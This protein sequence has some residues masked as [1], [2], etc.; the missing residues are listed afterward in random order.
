MGQSRIL[1]IFICSLFVLSG[2]AAL[3]YQV[4]WFKQLS[5][6]I[7]NTTYSQ[8]VVLATYMGG[9]AVGAWFWGKKADTLKNSLFLF[10]ILEI[11]LALYCF[12]YSPIFSFVEE[13][14]SA[15]VISNKWESDGSS[16]LFLK[17]LV[18]G[19]T[20]FFP[21]FLMGGTLPVLVRFLSLKVDQV[22]KN[23]SI[24][25]FI[26]SLGAVIGTLLAGFYLI[27]A[28]GLT[29]TTYFAALVELFVGLASLFLAKYSYGK[30]KAEN[31]ID[32]SKKN[33]KTKIITISKKQFNLIIA[34]AAFSGFSAMIYEVVW[35]RLLI[36]V[37]SS[38]TYSFTI[39]LAAFITG[40]AI[41]SYL[42]FK[43]ND[44]IKSPLLFVGYCQLFIVISIF[45]TLPFYEYL[46]YQIWKTINSTLNE[47]SSYSYYLFVQFIYVFIVLV[48]PTI[49]MGMSLPVLSRFAVS[50]VKKSGKTIGNIFAVNTLGTVLGSLITGLILIPF[51]GI[52][53]TIITAILINLILALSVFKQKDLITRNLKIII[54]S[55]IIMTGFIFFKNVNSQSWAYPIM[56]SQVPRQI[57][58]STPPETYDEFIAGLKKHDQI[59]YYNEGIGG[60]I[61][62]G[63]NKDQIY[64][65]TNGK[66][67]ANSV[68]DLRTQVS[69]GQTPIILHPKA[70]SVFVIGYGAGTTIGNVMTHPNVK[71]AEVAEISGEVIEASSHFNK[72]NEQP[73]KRKNLKVIKDDGVSALRLSTHKYDVIISQPSNPWSA[74]VGNLF[75]KEFFQDC[76]KKLR[77]G[78]YVA[79]WFSFYEM[80]DKSLRLILRTALDQFK[81]VS[82]WH[83]GSSDILLLCSETPFKFDLDQIEKNYNGVKDK[84]KEIN[85][86]TFSTFLSQQIISSTENLKNYVGP[87][88]INTEDHPLLELWAPEAYF[89]N[90][91]PTKFIVLDERKR[92]DQSNN[93]LLKK[94]MKKKGGLTQ[95]EIL[96]TGLFQ[97][98]GG[99]KELAFYMAEL[100]PDI[101]VTWSRKAEMAGDNNKAMEYLEMASKKG[102][103]QLG[104]LH[105][106]KAILHGKNGD[107]A[108]AISEIN[109][110]IKENPA[111]ANSH[112]QK[113][114]FHLSLKEYQKSM[115]ALEQ[116]IKLDPYLIDAYNNLAIIKGQQK[117][118][119]GVVDILDK[120]VVISDENSKVFFNRAYA[121]GFLSD[122]NGAIEDFTMTIKLDPGNGQ[123]L[124]LRGRAYSAIGKKE[125]ACADFFKAKTMGVSGA[126]ESITQLCQ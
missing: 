25:Y 110:S 16:V 36:P 89:Y 75:T 63:K 67:D 108:N 46:P 117:D 78:G 34:I 1:Y 56:L 106:Q 97:S 81:Y 118:Y 103:I 52:Y 74:G 126:A 86:N 40:I 35:L 71:Y 120:A 102:K 85:I 27:Q 95:E 111:N 38:S 23:V 15:T 41:G 37:L 29:K 94:Y 51:I 11:A 69:L 10:A 61:I 31:V 50:D 66:G 30:L 99:C 45:V 20:I 18:S 53:L 125:E 24:L 28:F 77:P 84:L 79:Q 4:V 12:F 43:Y 70:D 83:I 119:Q 26:N 60:T 115:L 65:S 59:L 72:I 54:A 92:F 6:F 105:R 107:F 48:L 49:F 114:T 98:L 57:N 88:E 82:L 32:H 55:A 17:F 7:G 21:T 9:L 87:G 14:F 124:I 91:E 68:T 100:N 93:L 123:A 42:T 8:S 5:Y 76:K 13:L 22:G 62:V 39:I 121:K 3:I 116:A 90:S 96:Q 122:F 73:L 58:R 101:Y 64:L 33:E 104:D 113:G 80:N 109:M 47:E 112:Y 2:I 19:A 44:K